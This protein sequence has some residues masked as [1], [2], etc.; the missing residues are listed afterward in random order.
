MG[1][2]G[3][4]TGGAGTGGAGTGGGGTGGGGSALSDGQVASVARTANVGEVE[5]AE[6]A[7]PKLEDAEVAEYAT[8]MITDHGAAATALDTLLAEQGIAPEPS[9]VEAALKADSDAIVAMLAAAEAPVDPLY[10]DSHVTAH[11]QVLD[12]IENVLLPETED[13]ALAEFLQTMRDDVEM[14]LQEAEALSE[15]P[16][17]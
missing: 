17:T 6:T 5:Q 7:Q 12:L 1:T 11:Q 3:D 16:G 14:H 15:G 13:E 10:I 8:M 9:D 2:G 4:G